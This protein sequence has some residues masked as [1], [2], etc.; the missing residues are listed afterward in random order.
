MISGSVTF[1]MHSLSCLILSFQIVHEEVEGIVAPPPSP[2]L[3]CYSAVGIGLHCLHLMVVLSPPNHRP[4]SGAILSQSRATD[5]AVPTPAPAPPPENLGP[6][7]SLEKS[8]TPQEV[9]PDTH[10]STLVH[11]AT[12]KQL[13]LPANSPN[14]SLDCEDELLNSAFV[15]EIPEEVKSQVLESSSA[16][17][18]SAEE[19]LSSEVSVSPQDIQPVGLPACPVIEDPP[20]EESCESEAEELDDVKVDDY[21]AR[22]MEDLMSRLC[23]HSLHGF[24]GVT[25]KPSNSNGLWFVPWDELVEHPEYYENDSPP[26]QRRGSL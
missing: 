1:H 21:V 5:K 17:L 8:N 10:N 9:Q 20:L 6:P 14:T 22:E 16:L 3:F 4:P 15:E 11:P 25:G 24:G 7:N 19:D 12:S 18:A 26:L 13:K 23:R 2:L